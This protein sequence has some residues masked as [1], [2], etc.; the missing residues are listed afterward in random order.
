V[1]LVS[2]EAVYEVEITTERPAI[3][4][5]APQADVR[6]LDP[7]VGRLAVRLT[8]TADGLRAD[9][10]DSG[11]GSALDGEA[12]PHGLVRDG[13]VLRVGGV[14]LRVELR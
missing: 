10:L 7:S 8:V 11:G 9:D 14:E 2:A 12:R 5:R 6:I 3:V 4:G 1:R 13:A